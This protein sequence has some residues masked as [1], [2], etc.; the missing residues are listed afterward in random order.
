MPISRAPRMTRTAISPRLAIRIFCSTGA[1]VGGVTS[2]E[3][4]R[5]ASARPA[6]G[7]WPSGWTVWHVAETASTNSDLLDAADLL[8]DRTVL[9]A[10]HQ[11]AGRGRLDRRWEAPPGANLLVST[12]FRSVPGDPGELT[13]RFGLAVVHAAAA[14][15][16]AGAGLKW[17]NDVVVGTAKL[18]GIL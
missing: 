16:V 7:T 9:F 8:P 11:T 3:H 12:L 5:P 15:G 14:V 13:R 18:A 10:D 2:S 17:P 4:V 6:S 1:N